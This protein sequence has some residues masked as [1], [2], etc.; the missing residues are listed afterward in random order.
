[1]EPW[2]YLKDL[3]PKDAPMVD[4]PSRLYC[5]DCRSVGISHCANPEYCGGM[6]P[7]QPKEEK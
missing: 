5:P 6:R 4:N 7:M 1:M 2:E 3:M